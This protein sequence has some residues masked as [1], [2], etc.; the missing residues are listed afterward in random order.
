LLLNWAASHALIAILIT[1][2]RWNGF[3]FSLLQRIRG[4][5]CPYGSKF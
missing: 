1:G 4:G 3:D 5:S 2:R